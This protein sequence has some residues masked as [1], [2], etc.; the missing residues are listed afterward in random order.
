MA[1]LVPKIYP[2]DVD[3]TVA[4]G[5]SFPLTIGTSEQNFVTTQ[6]IHDNLRNLI[7]TIPG[8]RVNQPTFGSDLMYLVFE[9]VSNDQLQAAALQSIKSAVAQ[10]LPDITIDSVEVESDIDRH[11]MVILID[12]S[13][14]GWASEN[15]LNIE[16][17]I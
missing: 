17:K 8:E 5:L 14:N 9:N 3:E 4:I 7:L 16:V 10:W 6:Q 12:Y 11:K 1:K 13:F 2:D 15:V